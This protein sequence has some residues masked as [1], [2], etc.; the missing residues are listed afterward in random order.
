MSNYC[1]IENN[2]VIDGPRRLPTSWKNVSGFHHMNP[3]K[4]KDYGWL[5][6]EYI[7]TPYDP[8]THYRV[9][10]SADIQVDKV[11]LTEVV[12]AYTPE[13]VKQNNWNNWASGM[14]DR[15]LF[16]QGGLTRTE[17]DTMDMIDE[18]DPTIIAKPKYKKSRDR[19]QMKRDYRANMP[20]MP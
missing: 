14:N 16:R 11:V 2:I 13:Q 10:P 17:E 9:S 19:R 15:D 18:I 20:P 5:P 8:A 7:E 4:L 1:L 6:V 3:D 12:V